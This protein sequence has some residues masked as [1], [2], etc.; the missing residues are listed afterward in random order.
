M[1]LVNQ[2]H[3]PVQQGREAAHSSFADRQVTAEEEEFFTG[4]SLVLKT[5]A[6]STEKGLKPVTNITL[7]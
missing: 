7:R 2:L 5:K 4:D 1:L 3:T 6:N